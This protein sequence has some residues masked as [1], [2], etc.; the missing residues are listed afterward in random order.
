MTKGTREPLDT[1]PNSMWIF[2]IMWPPI[3]DGKHHQI[4]PIL[5]LET[6]WIGTPR[7]G[8]E[9]KSRFSFDSGFRN[10]SVF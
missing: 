1:R 5:L 10:Y 4:N 3:S 8:E 6:F 2:P 9:I 7:E